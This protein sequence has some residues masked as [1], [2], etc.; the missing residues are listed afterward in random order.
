MQICRWIASGNRY[1][2]SDNNWHKAVSGEQVIIAG[3]ENKILMFPLIGW[4]GLKPSRSAPE[5]NNDPYLADFK[6]LNGITTHIL[7]HLGDL[8][9]LI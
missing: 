1:C 4:L 3:K 2:S 7:Q 9:K 6:G 8:V 5:W